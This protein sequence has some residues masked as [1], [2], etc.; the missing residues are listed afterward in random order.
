MGRPAALAAAMAALG[1]NDGGGA[2]HRRRDM[3]R[4]NRSQS[5]IIN[6]R[7]VLY[8]R[9]A[10]VG[11]SAS[12]CGALSPGRRRQ[13]IKR[14][15]IAHLFS[16]VLALRSAQF[17]RC[18]GADLRRSDQGRLKRSRTRIY[19]PTHRPPF[20]RPVCIAPRRGPRCGSSRLA[21]C[22]AWCC[23]NI[24]FGLC[25]WVAPAKGSKG[26]F[27]GFAGCCASPFLAQNGAR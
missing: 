15:I 3:L 18:A 22:D 12:L 7:T 1:G 5:L 23:C 24:F 25:Y 20:H 6:S 13:C 27:A 4:R 10:P 19:S 16:G 14:A 21:P 26:A 8:C 2:W 9:S 11:R 17:W